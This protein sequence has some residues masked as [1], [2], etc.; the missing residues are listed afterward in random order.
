MAKFKF[1]E[2]YQTIGILVGLAV[3]FSFLGWTLAVA[4]SL[5]KVNQ[6][7][8]QIKD[9]K[10][11]FDIIEE[12]DAL[13]KNQND[14]SQLFIKEGDRNE[15][16]GK[17]VAILKDKKIEILA[18]EPSEMQIDSFLYLMISFDVRTGFPGLIGLIDGLK[19]LKTPLALRYINMGQTSRAAQFGATRPSGRKE[20]KLR[21]EGLM[22]KE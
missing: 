8:R 18:A 13:N 15:V 7:K 16:L 9:S 5:K 22:K 3:F 10:A 4:P 19:T 14:S 1:K 11:R 2:N 12:I 20:A 17:V 21:L 6:Y